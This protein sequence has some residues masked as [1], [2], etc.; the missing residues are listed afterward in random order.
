[1]TDFTPTPTDEFDCTDVPDG[2]YANPAD[3]ATYF[4]CVSGQAY[5]ARCPE[6]LHYNPATDQCDDPRD[7]GAQ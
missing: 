2:N 6:G 5:L 7:A 4:A 3:P 1:M